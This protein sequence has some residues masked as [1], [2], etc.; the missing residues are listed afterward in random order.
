MA[1]V[2]QKLIATLLL[3]VL[4]GTMG[5]AFAGGSNLKILRISPSGADVP[6]G[7]E[8][9][10]QFDRG[11]VA[12][13]NMARTP[14]EVPIKITPAPG[15]QWRWLDTSE[16]ACRLPGKTKFRPATRYRITVGTALKALDGAQ[17]AKPV[18]A[19][20]TTKLPQVLWANFREW[21]SPVMPA[22]LV[23]FNYP[24]TAQAAAKH[25]Y[26]Q[27]ESKSAGGVRAEPF[28]KKREG[29]VWLRVPDVPGALVLIENPQP[30][31]PLGAGKAAGA[32]RVQWLISPEK[33]L[34]PGSRY[35]LKL[36]A[37]LETPLG[38][39]SGKAGMPQATRLK[40]YGAFH[41]DGVACGDTSNPAAIVAPG[42]TQRQPC[43][44]T[45]VHLRFTAPVPLSTLAAAQWTPPPLAASKMKRKWQGYPAWW[46]RI[47]RNATDADRPDAYPLPFDLKPMSQYRITVPAGVKDSFGR[48]LMAPVRVTVNTGHRAPFLNPP[49][50]EAVLEANEPTIA[51]LRFTNLDALHFTYRRLFAA[52]LGHVVPPLQ[53]PPPAGTSILARPGLIVKKDRVVTAPLGLRTVLDGRSG[54]VWGNI[55]W[56]PTRNRYESG[57]M[58]FFGEV[59]P[60]EVFAKVGYFN[61]VLW[62]SSFAT[63]LPVPNA[64][65]NLY[66]GHP[67]TLDRLSPLGSAGVE[68]NWQGLAILPGAL[69]LS[70]DW[71]EPWKEGALHYYI[72][73][74]HAKKLGF[75]PL[76]WSFRRSIG[77]ASDYAFWEQNAA[78][79]GHLHAWAV[80]EQGLYRPGSEVNFALFARGENNAELTA[81]PA[82]AYTLQIDDPLGN[83]VLKKRTIKLDAF[84]GFASSLHVPKTAP[85]G[86]YTIALSWPT[87][88]DTATREIGR[89]L[90]T[91]F[92]PASFKVNTLIEGEQFAPGESV[93]VQADAKLH[94][95]GPY[96]NAQTK[97]TTN[98]VA[99][100]FTSSNPVAA[101]F[102]FDGN[103]PDAP[104]SITIDEKQTQL[105]DKG[106]V[107]TQFKLPADG[108]IHYGSLQVESAVESARGTW[109]ANRASALYTARDRFIG[110]RL[111]Q[112]LLTT[113]TPATAQ[114]LVVNGKG[115]PAAGSAVQLILQHRKITS[116]RVKDAAGYF[117]VEQQTT[118]ET[119]DQCHAVSTAAPGTCML[120][121][122]HAGSYRIRAEVRDTRDRIQT[123]TLE[124]WATGPGVVLWSQKKRVTLVPDKSTYHVGETAH[125]LVQNPFPGATALVTVERYGV[126]WKETVYLSGSTP[127]I[128][129]PIG[130]HFFP[131]AY[132]SVTIFSPRAAEPV[133]PDLGRPE[134]ALGYVALPVAGKGS[135]L[136]VKVTA[137][138]PVYKPRKTVQV[139]VQVH[140]ENDKPS[141]K[142]RLVAVVTDQ[143]VLDLLAGGVNYYDPRKSFYA[144]PD[145]PDMINFSLAEQLLTEL[146]PKT[147][148]GKSPGGGGGEGPAVRSIFKYATYWNADLATDRNGNAEFSFKLPDNLT[149]WRI[150]VI[151]MT[152]GAAMG[153]GDAS[154]RVNLP[155]QIQPAL[156]NQAHVGDRFGAGFEVTNRTADKR[157]VATRIE[158]AGKPLQGKRQSQAR[159]TLTPYAH[160]LAWLKLAALQPGNIHLTAT[161]A[162]GTLGDAMATTIPVRRAETPV[163]ASE[164]G[165]R[166]GKKASVAIK[167]PASALPGSTT[168][169][170]NLA[171]TLIGGL[172][173]AFKALRDDPLE[174]W[175]VR[176]SRAVLASDYLKLKPVLGDTVAWPK[177]GDAIGKTLDAAADFQASNGGMAF[178]IPR[179]KFVSPWLSI[180]TAL[181]FNWLAK[182]GYKIPASAQDNLRHYVRQNILATAGTST[183]APVLKA[184]AL[185]ALAPTG[186]LQKGA[187][188]G[189]I[190][191]LPRLR[192]FGQALLLEAALDVK[193]K[194]TARTI[195]QS[196]L[197]HAE[198]SAGEISFN[199]E[200]TAAYLDILATPLRTNCAILDA[201]VKYGAATKGGGLVGTTPQKLMRWVVSARTSGGAWPNSQENVFCT[202]ATAHYAA[203]YE[204]PI[205]HLAARVSAAGKTIGK[206]EFAS[207]RTPA[208]RIS[209]PPPTSANGK[210]FDVTLAPSGKGRLYYTVN[211]TYALPP[212]A[213]GAAD[214][215]F[216]IRREYRVQHGDDWVEVTP[217]TKLE[218]GEVVRVD[219]Y[220]DVPTERHHVV[221]SDPLPGAF[222]AVNRQLATAML[223]APARQ[224]G[225]S[226][227]FFDYG[228][229]PNGSITTGGFYHRETGFD[230]VRF[231]ADNLPAGHYHLIYAAQVISP[232]DFIAP[233][234]T[235]KEIYQPDV[236]GRG[237]SQRIRA[238]VPEK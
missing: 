60:W 91:E 9:V 223:S 64:Q 8:I 58:N 70:A 59:T 200:E 194:S 32:A 12:L 85:M 115:D 68:T 211:L 111:N 173:G 51:P 231:Y 201:L 99:R 93:K 150:L 80:T 163:T 44:P 38:A 76:D 16:L 119:E 149:R 228:A 110:L 25:L 209:A 130:K 159:F 7:Q 183:S 208:K 69:D 177:A 81:P 112:W 117:T 23:R 224:P 86:W 157:Q 236:F 106:E 182:A 144:P 222:Q 41:F 176:L 189:M 26:F 92:V 187:V 191:E 118:W 94:S 152:P 72:G 10:F 205:K 116:A 153:L 33:P 107:A 166:V 11:M 121:P 31:T 160:E 174:T 56:A 233:A 190:P 82:L 24:V 175:E 213:L 17:L 168:L 28:T 22:Y 155:I 165:S 100:G 89:F 66:V 98:I 113:G 167:V 154:V 62:V 171:P 204:Q 37:G 227:L 83:A 185:A 40:T 65:V 55:D 120:T 178:W 202:T 21:R 95:G 2:A 158:A 137:A 219:L 193:D 184:G 48:K 53:R 151:A 4:A 84:G 207:Q 104:D 126:L 79:Y 61:T 136:A 226:V 147:G 232:G 88:T 15:C 148:K 97:F 230:T 52:D 101:G 238:A 36:S 216:S 71:F 6:P 34:A 235:V 124:T 14:V 29:P 57:D 212:G 128:D 195:A 1:K 78:T 139:K 133:S 237:K 109:V 123:T 188:A 170:I 47:S 215:G 164:F 129:V 3:A 143:A 172:A 169:D 27:S 218:R 5:I 162:A 134:L 105:D 181:A 49:P 225:G 140:G 103:P 108:K 131:G 87:A 96:T 77:T 13:G 102:D 206:A 180:Y 54:I 125:V 221:L 35:E 186:T 141:A 114:Y 156:P 43:E 179:D 122:K 30:Q 196:I 73:V 161:A 50:G 142:T 214:A 220:L 210:S 229:W 145:G 199:E 90:V 197:S 45:E 74:T 18:S 146:Q 20:F 39:L 135:S 132:L 203:A 67:D 42:G 198:E 217:Q 234:P 19:G 138:R 46:L 192:L 75:L 63:G 127:V